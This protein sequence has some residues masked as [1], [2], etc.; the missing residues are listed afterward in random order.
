MKIAIS[1]PAYLPWIGYLDLIDQVDTF[2]LLDN[3]QFEK[4]S[5]QQRN[6]IKTPTGLQWLTVPVLFHGRFGQLINQ[7]E[8]RDREFWRNHLRAIELNYRRAP[9]FDDYFEDLRSRMTAQ[10]NFS[11]PALLVE[12]DIVL[13]EWFVEVLGIQTRLLLSSQLNQP[14]RRT[15]LLANICDALYT[16]QY[17][18]PLGS[19]DYLLPEMEVLRDKGIEVIFQHYEHPRYRQ[20]FSP[21]HP[22]ASILDLIFNEGGQSL[23][24]LRSGR[25]TPFLPEEAGDLVSAKAGE[26]R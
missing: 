8:I 24:I 14:G 10:I 13:V 12:L 15:E 9:F 25:R 11:S 21:F 4:Q 3:V 6:R 18:S 16:T 19:A 26:K 17:L 5:W 23:E 7:V 20:L 2:V 1:Q 22:Y